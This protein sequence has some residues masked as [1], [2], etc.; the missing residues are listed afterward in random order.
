M[1]RPSNGKSYSG[2]SRSYDELKVVRVPAIGALKF[3]GTSASKDQRYVNGFFDVLTDPETQKK[4]YFFTKRPGY[5]QTGGSQPPA[6]AGVARGCISWNNKLYSV[7]G[8]KI[9]SGTTD[10]GVTLTTSTGM[11]GF[12]FTRPGI[13]TQYLAINDGVKLF[14]I[15][16]TDVVT[17]ITVNF[18]TPNTGH[19]VYM[20]TYFLV[21][22]TDGTIW[23]CDTDDPTTWNVAKF[24][25]AQQYN[26]HGVGL[27][28]QNNVL[29]A[30]LDN[31]TQMF[32]DNA[33]AVGSFLT[34]YEQAVQ[35]F[36]CAS[37]GSIVSDE[38]YVIWVSNANNGGYAVI[39]MDG[40]GTFTDI[41]TAP[42]E[43]LLRAEGT[44][45]SSCYALNIRVTGKMFY[46]LSLTSSGRTLVYDYDEDL[47][48]EWEAAAGNAVWPIVSITQHLNAL[49]VQHATN[50]W[51]Y[52]LSESVYQDDATNFT[53]L[54][55]TSRVDF[56]TSGTRKF[57]RMV[58]LVCDTQATT[59]NASVQYYEDDY[60]T[61]STARTF[62]MSQPR[63][64]SA[65]W[66]MWRRRAWQVS[67]AGNN[68]SRW[69]AL[70]FRIR[71][72]QQ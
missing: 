30:F 16:T 62:D 43:R 60:T 29:I 26:G 13:V 55:R 52:V 6:G 12:E 45:I 25:T 64:F 48:V 15:S 47:W 17:T 14:I 5:T 4:Q 39:R 41:S 54:W 23:N 27:L 11:C 19:L 56:D 18:P 3:R 42:I 37:G 68:P 28:H 69:E 57:L 53:V 10:L 66:G 58:D 31:A 40:I 2:A 7:Y 46:I 21:M 67:Y 63:C 65:G 20:D 49:R 36:G 51:I 9:Y 38:R 61:I 72:G 33:N 34:L 24:I 50:G 22:K 35:Q 8:T 71:M 44:S 59:A 70:E 32:Y 1:A